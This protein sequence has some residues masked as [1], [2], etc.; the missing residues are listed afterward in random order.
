MNAAIDSPLLFAPSGEPRLFSLDEL[1]SLSERFLGLDPGEVGGATA[2]AS[3]AH[4]LAERCIDADRI[5]ALVDVILASRQGVDP[6]VRE[7]IGLLGKEEM[8]Q[9][10]ALGPFAAL[11]KLGEGE[12]S[13]VYTAR[14]GD[15]D[16]V[17]K[18]LRRDAIRDKRAVQRFLAATRLA[19]NV[20]HEGLPEGVEAGEADGTYWVSYLRVD[21]QPLSTR[22]TRTGPSHINEAKAVLRGILEPL[23]ALH[24][25]RLAHGGI[26]MENVLVGRLADGMPHVVL[27]DFGTDR[28]RQRHAAVNGHGGAVL[29]FASPKTIAPEQVRGRPADA[30][31]D[32]YAFGALMY[33]LLSGKPVFPYETATDAAF[34][35]VAKAPDPPSHK[36]PR[37]WI[38]KDVDQFVLSLLAKEPD[39]RPKD[40]LAILDGLEVV[41]R[42]SAAMRAAQPVLGGP[43]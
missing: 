30:A 20:A 29:T 31:T 16:R 28:L 2:K 34:A 17:V 4:A 11:R 19:A 13:V 36:A 38:S 37:G 12:L 39:K 5:D 27:V 21:A 15:E 24:K 1:T 3:F 10:A 22:F 8:P 41:A 25:A 32:V 14:R 35:H 42:T 33:E 18:V 9:G 23:A 40:A 26:K 43:P 7:A 6:R